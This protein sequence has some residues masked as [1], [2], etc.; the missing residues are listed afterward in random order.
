LFWEF[1]TGQYKTLKGSAMAKSYHILTIAAALL[2]PLSLQ[3][4]IPSL[5]TGAS[6]V[7]KA[8]SAQAAFISDGTAWSCKDLTC[9]AAT[10]PDLPVSMICARVVR[11]TGPVESFTIN[12]KAL[13]AAQLAT[14]NA[15]A[16]H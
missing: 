15:K 4:Q 3:A 9:E 7:L 10:T 1:Y 2:A 14:C 16:K 13:T 5:A 6:L 8:P 12:G 11:V